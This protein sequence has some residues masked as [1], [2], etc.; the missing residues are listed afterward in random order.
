MNIY[1]IQI[2]YLDQ[3]DRLV[4]S[5]NS[6][7]NEE[8]RLFLTRRIVVIFLKML[9]QTIEYVLNTKVELDDIKESEIS[10]IN[11][12]K[13]VLGKAAHQQM[14]K[15]MQNQMHHQNIV[16]ESNYDTPFNSGDKFP[17]G[18]SPVLVS[19]VTINIDKS[20]NIALI[21]S[22]T[23][24]KDIN[25]DINEQILHNLSDVLIKVMPVT[26]WNIGLTNTKGL[27]TTEEQSNLVLH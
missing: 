1:Q 14:E 24:N 25:L 10:D 8:I 7:E 4:L 23:N 21:L 18:E 3:E 16:N 6:K 9:N 17:I 27:L 12:P 13:G 5:I 2:A 15:Q 20:D 11:I 19:K 22:A 26:N